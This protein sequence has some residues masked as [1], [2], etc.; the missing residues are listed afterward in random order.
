ME[1]YAIRL[2]P[3][4]DLKREIAQLARERRVKAGCVVT[5]VGSLRVANL[6]FANQP[7]GTLLEGKYEIVSLVG[8]F[9]DESAHLHLSI[10]DATGVTVG[11]H[12]LEGNLIYTTAELVVGVLPGLAFTREV[13]PAYG[14]RELVVRQ[15]D[16]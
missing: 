11:G 7:T 2:K 4:Q 1:T 10:S 6:R 3:G 9:S 12:L 14:Y 13:D 15:E 8:T 5:C 16:R